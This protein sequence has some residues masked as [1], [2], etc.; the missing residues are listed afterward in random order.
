MPDLLCKL[1]WLD[2]PIHQSPVF[3]PLAA[4]PVLVGAEQVGKIFANF[5]LVGQSRQPAGSRQDSE[6]RK[7]RQAHSGRTVVDEDNFIAGQRQFIPS[8]RGCSIARG[9]KLKA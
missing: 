7:L 8:T 3:C 6:Q 5:S 4:H 9:E 1:L 2:D